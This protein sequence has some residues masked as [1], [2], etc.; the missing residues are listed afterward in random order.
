MLIKQL[1]EE[2]VEYGRKM[3][4]SSLVSGTWGNISARD[5][6]TGLIAITPTSKEYNKLT[7]EDITVLDESGNM[8]EGKYPPSS[9]KPMHVL[10]YQEKKDVFAIVHTHSKFA[11]AF[12]VALKE[13]PVVIV[14]LAMFVGSSVKIVKFKRPGTKDLGKE[15]VN[16]LKDSKTSAVLL[17]NHGVLTVGPSLK[18]AFS[19]AVS[20]EDAAEVYFRSLMLGN[21]TVISKEETRYLRNLILHKG[22][23]NETN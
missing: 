7:A 3:R 23:K 10:I 19:A 18:V 22:G 14:D 2:I 1:R 20:V 6:K 8:I 17:Q 11:T 16:V 12:S 4:N 13:I 9:E 21:Y 15:V 5:C